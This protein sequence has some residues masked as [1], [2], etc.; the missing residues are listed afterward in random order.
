MHRLD[1]TLNYK[2]TDCY[3]DKFSNQY[4]NQ[5]QIN[6]IR[7]NIYSLTNYVIAR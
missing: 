7:R 2:T 6:E 1:N 3:P 5:V 4:D